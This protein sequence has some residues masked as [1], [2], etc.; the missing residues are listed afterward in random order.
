MTAGTVVRAPESSVRLMLTQTLVQT[1][2]ILTRWGRDLVTVMEALVLPVAFM[3]VLY[4]V[5]GNL[6][7]AMTHDSALYSIVPLLALGGA[8][9]GSAF[10]AIDLMREQQSGL[11]TRLWVM[12]VHRASGPLARIIAEAIRILVTTGVMLGAGV[13]LG[14]RFRGG[15]LATLMWLGVPVILGMAFAA[16]TTAIALFTSKTLVVEAVELWQLLLIFF[17]TGLLPLNQYPHWI[18]P[19]VAHQPVSYAITAMRGLSAGGPVLAPMIATLLWSAGIAAACAVPM[20]IGY[21]RAS[22][23]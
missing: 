4:I 22:T 17:S 5:L 1:Q 3:L 15:A 20:A 23:H 12:P 9:S 11:L 21:R 6:I 7:Y 16:L 13:A 18:Q 19:V 2:R 10:V 14:F 8:V